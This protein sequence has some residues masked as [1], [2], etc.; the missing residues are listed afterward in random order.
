M[1]VY[2]K[3]QCFDI[4]I[5]VCLCLVCMLRFCMTCSMIICWSRM[6]EAT[7]MEEGIIQ[8]RFQDCLVGRHARLL[9][10]CSEWVCCM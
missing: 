3:C 1:F 7:I 10:R 2:R 8:I 6:K 5:V 4:H 9:L